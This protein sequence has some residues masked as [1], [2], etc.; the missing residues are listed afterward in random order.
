MKKRF[1]AHPLMILSFI[2]PT[3]FLLLLP[4]IKGVIQYFITKDI[5]GIIS[6]E[7]I[8]L[9]ILLVI[10]VLR[11][12]SYSLI[13]NSKK[14]IVEIEY[15]FIFRRTAKIDITK[16]SS[17]QTTQNPIDAIFRSVTYKIN[18]EAGNRDQT[19]FE[20]KLSRKNSAEVSKFLYGTGEPEAVSFS[21]L[22]VA[23]LAAT[24]SSAFTGML[25]AVPIINRAGNLLGIGISDMLIHELNHISNQVKTYFPPIVNTITLVILLAYFVSF[26]YSFLKY[27]NFKLYLEKD[28]LGVRSGIIVRTRT[29]F[30]KTAINNIKIEQTLLMRLL[31]RYALKVSVGGYGDSKSESEVII[32][33][34]ANKEIKNQLNEYFP[35]FVPNEKGIHAAKTKLTLSRFLF[36]PSI[37]FLTVVFASIWFI[38]R[39]DLF[40]RL[41]FFLTIVICSLILCLAYM[42]VFQFYNA[43]ISFG[44]NIFARSNKGLRTYE[45]YCHKE[46]VGEIR[47]V[48]FPPD[49]IYKTCRVKVLIRSERADNIRVK[50]LDYKTAKSEIYKCF[51]IE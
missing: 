29:S 33:L 50:F 41:I 25:V 30:R 31:C 23:I 17:V 15:G 37:Y 38:I 5:D 12:Q 11:W 36:L 9:A 8:V 21:V 35:F 14:N 26:I 18:T 6:L 16:L 39:F 47:L 10:A 32:P 46:N 24:T 2:K 45:L 42:G 40:T 28:K 49:R 3:L 19:D 51:N 20:F 1:K 48:Q 13:C 22:K 27:V 4:V 34:G 7:I 44:E 43:K